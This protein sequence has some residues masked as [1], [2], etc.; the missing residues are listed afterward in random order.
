MNTSLPIVGVLGGGDGDLV[1]DA[2]PIAELHPRMDPDVEVVDEM[3]ALPDLH[4]ARKVGASRELDAQMQEIVDPIGDLA[5]R[6]RQLAGPS[7]VA[8]DG[9]DP[10]RW[11]EQLTIVALVV[12]ADLFEHGW[13]RWVHR[14]S[15]H[16]R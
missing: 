12:L 1:H 7:P 3:R 15:E 10:Q 6:S 14:A 4:L 13:L 16:R 9:K 5:S 8:I 2:N 11:I